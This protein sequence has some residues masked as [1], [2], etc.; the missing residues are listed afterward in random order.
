VVR[1][2]HLFLLDFWNHGPMVEG[3]IAAGRDRGYLHIDWNGNVMPC[4]FMPYVAA[5][6]FEIYDRGGTLND[7]WTTLFVPSSGR[8]NMAM[9]AG[10][11]KEGN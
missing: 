1:Q 2:R 9:A 8:S 5:N 10:A 11:V 4:V 3:C 6:L 7:V